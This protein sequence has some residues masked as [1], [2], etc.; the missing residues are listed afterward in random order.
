MS[1]MSIES[2]DSNWQP[3]D[4]LPDRLGGPTTLSMPDDWTLSTPWQRAQDE[5]DTGG[6]INDVVKRL[7][8]R[9][10]TRPHT[11]TGRGESDDVT[12]H[13]LRHNVAYRM[14]H[15]YDGYT[16]YNVRNQLRHPRLATTEQKYDHFD[17]V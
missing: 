4:D 1:A 8:Q 16:L 6:P 13:T 2:P 7:A 17:S 12:A 10:E 5:A 15:S 3:S 9:A 11:F 14:L